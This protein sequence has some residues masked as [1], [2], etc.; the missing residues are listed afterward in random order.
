MSLLR[1]SLNRRLACGLAAMA[2]L[3]SYGTAEKESWAAVPDTMQRTPALC[4]SLQ[5]I[6]A[7]ALSSGVSACDLTGRFVTGKGVGAYVPKR[8]STTTA[9]ALRAKCP[10]RSLGDTS[11]TRWHC[12]YS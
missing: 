5:P 11:R 4:H 3:A 6:P 7:E 9:H 10:R 12:L 8:G 2:C 1:T